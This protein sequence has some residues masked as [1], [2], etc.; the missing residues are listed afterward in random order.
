MG[1]KGDWSVYEIKDLGCHN[2][3]LR[4]TVK[5]DDST[6]A[7]SLHQKNLILK[8]SRLSEWQNANQNQLHY[9]LVV[10]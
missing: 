2:S 8:L 9:P 6:G 10:S 1:L 4:M 3:V 7:I 5:F